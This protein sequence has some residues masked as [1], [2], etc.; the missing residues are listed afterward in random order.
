[1]ITRYAQEFPGQRAHLVAECGERK[2]A[3]RA[4][5]GRT[6]QRRG[7]WGWTCNVSF[8]HACRT[9]LRVATAHNDVH[10]PAIPITLNLGG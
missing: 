6:P 9:C 2:V 10:L 3:Y 4:L 7:T 1:M 5:C 8:G